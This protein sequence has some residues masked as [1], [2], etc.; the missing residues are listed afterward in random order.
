MDYIEFEKTIKALMDMEDFCS[1]LTMACGELMKRNGTI[2]CEMMIPTLTDYVIRLLEII[3]NDKN[4]WVSY[5]VF[6]L[7]FGREYKD[8]MITD[9]DG[10]NIKLATTQDLWDLLND[11]K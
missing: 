2:D 6:D 10:A 7:N 3:L 11:N 4:E 8:G 1:T 5:F 9:K